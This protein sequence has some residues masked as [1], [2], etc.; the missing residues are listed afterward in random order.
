MRGD[1][2]A[3]CR[4]CQDVVNVLANNRWFVPAEP[5]IVDRAEYSDAGNSDGGIFAEK[6]IKRN[7]QSDDVTWIICGKDNGEARAW[8]RNFMT[9]PAQVEW[10]KG[11]VMT[12]L[13]MI[14]GDTPE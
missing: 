13:N 3:V 9:E 10:I 6:S 12:G 11:Q 5:T 7:A 14:L 1:G 4:N 8:S 2:E